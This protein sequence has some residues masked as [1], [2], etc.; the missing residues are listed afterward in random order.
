MW[1]HLVSSTDV[2]EVK[3][4][5]IAMVFIRSRKGN[6]LVLVIHSQQSFFLCVIEILTAKGRA[7]TIVCLFF[8]LP[9][10]SC[11]YCVL[12]VFLW[13]SLSGLCFS[14]Y[15]FCIGGFSL[16]SSVLKCWLVNCL[17]PDTLIWTKMWECST[18][19]GGAYVMCGFATSE[20]FLTTTWNADSA[21]SNIWRLWHGLGCRNLC[22]L[23]TS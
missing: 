5:Y 13:M 4:L 7:F 18:G 2:T 9:F 21:S 16:W 15:S 6:S 19:G 10:F 12:L 11:C 3:K 20:G 8:F 17:E 22:V 14:C 1:L 23:T